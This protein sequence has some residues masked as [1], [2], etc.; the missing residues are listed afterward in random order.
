MRILTSGESHGKYIVAT[1]EGFPK[2]V[3]IRREFI[4]RELSRRMSGYGR[5]N[6]MN[7]EADAAEVVSGLRNGLT[8]GSPITI[9]VQ[10][11]DNRLFAFKDDGQA[12]LTMP[13]PAHADLAGALKYAESDLRNILERASARETVGRV[14][15]GALCKEFLSNFSIDI[16]SFTFSIGG[17][18]TSKKAKNISE[19]RKYTQGSLLNCIDKKQEAKII[20]GINRAA[21]RGDT[22]GGIIEI[23]VEGVCPG[24]GS[25]MHFDKRLDALLSYNLMSIPSIKGVETG[26]GFDYA[27]GQGSSFHDQIFYS[28][29]KG[30]FRKTNNS[31]GIEGGVSNGSPIVVRIAMKP[32]PTLRL[33]LASIDMKSKKKAKAI[34]ERSDTCAV[35]A[36]GVIAESMSA[37]TIMQALLEKF[38]CDTLKEIKRSYSAYL[39]HLG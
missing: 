14:C 24:L 17:I 36:A 25:F 33:P 28:A 2:G 11:K 13:R 27:H 26:A 19:I 30:F 3:S 29:K 20:A 39:A 34:V 37:I 5:G 23:W 1:V 32:I 16:S 38:G 12:R 22:L 9:L 8:L 15:V 4:N 21:V 10:N 31:G 7:I 6:R 35:P 18:K